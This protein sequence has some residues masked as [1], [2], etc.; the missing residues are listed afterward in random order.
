MSAAKYIWYPGEFEICHTT[1]VHS[2]RADAGILTPACWKIPYLY[3]RCQFIKQFST[4]EDSSFTVVTDSGAEVTL[5]GVRYD[6]N[7]EI[8]L[9]AGNHDIYI[10][11]SNLA[12]M[13][14]CFID[15]PYL[16][17]D[18]TWMTSDCT[19]DF[20]PVACDPA[21]TR[22][23]D[24]PS[25]FPFAYKALR[26]KSV[27]Q[28]SKSETLY[29]FG[30]ETFG[31][32]TLK[33]CNPK[34]HITVYL[35][36]S[37]EE[38]L[39][40]T[41]CYG[42]ERL[43]GSENYTLPAHAF[44]YILVASD[45]P[46]KDTALSAKYEYL[47][48]EDIGR[49][50]CNDPQVEKVWKLC[51]YTYHLCSREFLLDGIKRDRWVWS[52]DA[53]QTFQIN[54]YLFFDPALTRRTIIALLGKPPYVQHIN[55]INDY[56]LYLFLACWDYYFNTGDE[57]FVKTYWSRL[58]ALWDFMAGRLDENGFVVQRKG[59]WI[60]IDWCDMD[61]DGPN[62]TEQIILWKAATAMAQLASLVG[63]PY[64]CYVNQANN[65]K[66]KIFRYFWDNEKAAFIDS[67]TSGNRR[68]SRHPQIFAI[69]FDL[70]D[71]QTA[72]GL[73]ERVLHDDSVTQITTPYFK[74]YELEALCKTGHLHEAQ[75]MIDSYWGGM[76]RLGATS[77]W[78]QYIPEETGVQHYAMY[79]NDFG[80]SLC[81]AWGAGPICFLGKYCLGVT[82]TDVAYRSFLVEPK[83]GTYENFQ[84]VVPL[85][86]GTVSVTYQKGTLT[87]QTDR[88]GGTVKVDGKTYPLTAGEVFTLDCKL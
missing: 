9:P 75:E 10:R 54:N 39:S 3:S 44:R 34:A 14:T 21:F 19:E 4:P 45:K 37:R 73:A 59:D 31:P 24:H 32:V 87:V 17:T 16:K 83:A 78:E 64:E 51:A 29:D 58:K 63:E 8:P 68:V 15:S 33:H 7:V 11:L 86:A 26:S 67:Y 18:E 57:A 6:P 53:Y 49:F 72:K 2:R 20:V 77:V 66:E 46:L 55:T 74:F 62:A 12:G 70:V 27:E 84:G 42:I 61:K 1:L 35:G 23:Q 38:T 5:D 79:G 22:P 36:E 52:G 71:R 85:P 50:S 60:F 82:P 76:L 81:H 13:C 48:L 47:P 56:T 88:P 69:L 41:K 28:L 40:G 30:K 65:L 43:H 25:K 80:R